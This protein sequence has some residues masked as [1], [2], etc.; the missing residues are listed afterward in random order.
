MTEALIRFGI[1][2]LAPEIIEL[3]HNGFSDFTHQTFTERMI[4]EKDSFAAEPLLLRD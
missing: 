1:E 2:R 3:A 4:S